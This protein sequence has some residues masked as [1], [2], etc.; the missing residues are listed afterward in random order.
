M[1]LSNNKQ[2]QKVKSELDISLLAKFLAEE[3]DNNEKQLVADWLSKSSKNKET[4]KEFEKFGKLLSI[5]ILPKMF[6]TAT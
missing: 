4:M 5:P 1:P 2:T 6:L 3:C